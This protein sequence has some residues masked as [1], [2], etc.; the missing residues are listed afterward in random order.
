MRKPKPAQSAGNLDDD[1]NPKP[2]GEATASAGDDGGAPSTPPPSSDKPA[3]GSA[4][5]TAGAAAEG[6][7][8]K[9]ECNVFDEANLEGIL[10]KS[11]C[12]VADPTGQPPDLTKKLEVK[13]TVMP[14]KV[15]PGGHADVQVAFINHTAQTMPL[16]FTI[17][18][19]PRFEIEVYDKKSNR[20]DL[21][22]NQPPPLPAGMAARVP[23]I[24]RPRASSSP[25]TAPRACRSRGTR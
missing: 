23:A 7:P 12:E 2:E 16:Y 20:V 22:K 19:M 18:P 6:A 1:G 9:D 13:V 15:A 21:P 17:D 3:P 10:L 4:D 11:G 24:P 8:K 25:P 5:D 14:P